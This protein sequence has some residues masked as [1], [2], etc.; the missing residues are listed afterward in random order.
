LYCSYLLTNV[1]KEITPDKFLSNIRQVGITEQFVDVVDDVYDKAT[2]DIDDKATID[3]DDKANTNDYANN[4]AN[5]DVDDYA[6]IDDYANANNKA[7]IDVDNKSNVDAN[8]NS[9]D[10]NKNNVY[11]NNLKN[12]ETK[13]PVKK[14]QKIRYFK[15]H[16]LINSE[17]LFLAHVDFEEIYNKDD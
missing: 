17:E 13:L 7:A 5:I 3:V 9:I 11:D 8:V 12:K 2:I 14:K 1:D 6:N 16:D 15:S 10:I 4:K